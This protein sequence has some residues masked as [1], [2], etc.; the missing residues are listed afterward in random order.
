MSFEDTLKRIQEENRL[1][2]ISINNLP[3]ITTPVNDNPFTNENDLG[4]ILG[5]F[6]IGAGNMVNNTLFGGL[7]GQ[8][9]GFLG[10]YVEK[11]S[12]FSGEQTNDVMRLQ[13]YGYSLEEAR[14]IY[15]YR[16]SWLTSI[17][18]WSLD[19]QNYFGDALRE[20]RTP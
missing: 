13:D 16:D 12:P 6:G 7:L 11:F 19:L 10:S 4:T 3:T 15:P 5:A 20:Q 2:N 1:N 8:L 17:G 14:K 9:P 18:K